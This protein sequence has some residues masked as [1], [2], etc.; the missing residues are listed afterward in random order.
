MRYINP[1]KE[2]KQKPK[3]RKWLGVLFCLLVILASITA[4]GLTCYLVYT[5]QYDSLWLDLMQLPYKE[6]T[7]IYARD[8]NSTQW[9][10]YARLNCTQNKTW[11]PMEEIPLSLQHAF[12]AVED[13]NFYTHSG[14]SVKR[15]AYALLNEV[16]YALTGSYFGGED[17]IK[18]G[19][20][21]ITQQLVK[22]LT[23]D[24]ASDS[25]AGYLR[26]IREIYRALKLENDYDKEEILEAYLNI[27][28]FTGN[29]AGVQAEAQKLFGKDVSQLELW[30]CASIAAITKN[31]SRYNPVNNEAAHVERRDYVLY[32]MWKQN[33]IT[34]EEY[35]AAVAQPLKLNYFSTE[36]DTTE[37]T[38]YFTD[39][40]I[41]DLITDFSK[42]Y[43]LTRAQVTDLLYNGGLRIYATVVPTLQTQ[44]EKVMQSGVF[45]KPKVYVD[46]AVKD[47]AGNPVYDANNAV[48]YQSVAQTPQAA[49]VSVNYSGEL[50]A[51]VGGLDKKEIS[52]GFNRGTSAIRQVGSTM[53]PIGAYALAIEKN[54]C[55]YSSAYMDSAVR[56]IED[57]ETGEVKSWPRN[58]NNQYSNK[59]ILVWDA[60]S[61]SINTI[62]VR[63]GEDA[64]VRNIYNFT[65]NKL[66]ITTFTAEDKDSGPMILGSSTLGVT[67]YEMAGAYMMFG[68]GGK[69]TTLHSYVSV[70]NGY[71]KI[72]LK[73]EIETEQVISAETAYI[74]NRLL[75]GVMEGEGTGAGYSVPGKMDS[76][77]KTGTTSDNR[78]HWF[79]GLT[80]YYVTAT[81][82]G[83][84]NNYPLE[85]NYSAH[86]PTLAWRRVMQN[87]QADLEYKDFPVSE[88][89]QEIEFCTESGAKA[90]ANCPSTK[91]GY[92]KPGATPFGICLV[93]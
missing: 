9:E 88:N 91:T 41:E 59:S 66:D 38:S 37:I 27:I 87:A 5:T 29:T 48:V 16:K 8:N 90:G 61:R 19:A 71:G 76:I 15:T 93:H 33:Y 84:D 26:K 67:P 50:C 56:E 74:M 86:P 63:V 14:I 11:V 7:V 51:V 42:N 47:E 25:T 85:V 82:Y 52:R 73:P 89:V 32:E 34:Q 2:K 77:G 75:E 39:A 78:D 31:P 49:M 58:F 6:A 30:E 72:L 20:S 83:Y 68:N 12:V 55:H 57:E 64:G 23:Q 60:L 13:K 35:D 10:E 21:T 3:K 65:R 79:I 81:W 36:K 80:P 69:M 22:N 45:P 44:M 53:K 43:R 54:K 17:G 24:N 1:Q 18:Q 28:S 62:A 92:Y 40:L 46:E 70:Q 4:V